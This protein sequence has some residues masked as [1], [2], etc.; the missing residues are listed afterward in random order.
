M[1]VAEFIKYLRKQPQHIQVAYAKYSEQC[2]LEAEE[3]ELVELCEPRPD[4]WIQN[5]RPDKAA[6]T[7]LLLPGN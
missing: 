1:T 4:G 3:I 2:L 5:R 6:V 7:Y